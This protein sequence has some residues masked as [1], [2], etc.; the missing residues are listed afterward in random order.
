MIKK[1]LFLAVLLSIV[2]SVSAQDDYFIK[3]QPDSIN[4]KEL[5][6][7]E[8]FINKHFEYINIADWEKGMRFM[9][10][11]QEYYDKID[12]IPCDWEKIDVSNYINHIITLDTIYTYTKNDP[13]KMNILTRFIFKTTDNHYL[14]YQSP[15]SIDGLRNSEISHISGLAYL[16]D[17][18]I[19]RKLLL[20][21]TLYTKKD[22]AFINIGKDVSSIVIKKFAPYRVKE[23]GIGNDIEPVKI[24][25]ENPEG[26]NFFY[27]MY[28][29]KTN[30][31]KISMAKSFESYFYL[32]NPK[33][34]YPNISTNN[35]NLIMK[36][37][38]R[39]GWN[40]ILCELSWGKP[41]KINTTRGNFG[42]HEQWVYYGES[43]L[44]FENGK[45]TAIQN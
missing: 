24:L 41:E 42:I 43:Y 19:A 30:T 29:S 12:L 22:L 6:E 20:G 8:L 44:Y 5:G 23:I 37:K 35:W 28:L 25:L 32:S 1:I 45:L 17:I 26:E 16:K 2:A 11:T 40:K 4:S 18:D 7:E 10:I 39:I 38:V 27:E 3:I 21:K 34:K 31:P 36:G 14:E 9:L 15:A 33:N 13:Y